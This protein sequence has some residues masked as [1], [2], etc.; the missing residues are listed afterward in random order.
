MAQPIPDA[1]QQQVDVLRDDMSA[2]LDG[3]SAGVSW[4]AFVGMLN[5]IDASMHKILLR[6]GNAALPDR[7]LVTPEERDEMIAGFTIPDTLEGESDARG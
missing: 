1:L 4:A 7:V 5:S 3:Y 2:F 6:T